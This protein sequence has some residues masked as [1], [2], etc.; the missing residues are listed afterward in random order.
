MTRGFATVMDLAPTI[1]DLAGLKHPVPSGQ[2]KGSYKGREV[3]GL[4]GKSWVK[5]LSSGE[6]FVDRPD[7]FWGDDEFVGWELF[8]RAAIRKGK[9]KVRRLSSLGTLAHGVDRLH[10]SCVLG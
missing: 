9:W 7:V 6:A 1:L 10:A 3:Y 2:I 5:S 8:G 4:R